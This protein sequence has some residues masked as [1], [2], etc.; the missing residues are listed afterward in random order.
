MKPS[1]AVLVIC[2]VFGAGGAATAAAEEAA[3]GREARDALQYYLL[4]DCEVGEERTALGEVLRHAESLLPELERLLLEGPPG[5][6]VEGTKLEVHRTWERRAEFLD[7]DPRLGLD[8][9]SRLAAVTTPRT[10]YVERRLRRLDYRYRER[11][12]TALAAI[13]T[14]AARRILREA[15]YDAD[16]DV[17][18]LIRSAL[19]RSRT[20]GRDQPHLQEAR[21]S[22]AGRRATRDR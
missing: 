7:E 21:T 16:D 4:V 14:P 2:A 5:A 20:L 15:L 6:V 8:P 17:R 10:I 12:V 3:P 13:D 19:P 18:E 11:A 22:P 9:E 1:A